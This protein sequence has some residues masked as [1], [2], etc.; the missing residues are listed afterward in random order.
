MKIGAI[1][2]ARTSSTRLPEKVLKEL[3]YRS[4]ITVFEQVIRRLKDSKKL[5]EIIIATTTEEADN[6]IVEI[7]QKE[8]VKYFRGSRDNVLERYYLAAQENHLDVVIRVTSDCPCIDPDIVDMLVDEHLKSSAEYTS[9]SLIRTFPHG[10]DVEVFN[11]KA[12]ET[13]H[14]RAS[15]KFEREH[16][17]PYI[18]KTHS[19][20]F[21]ILKVKAPDELNAPDIR[22]TLDTEEDYSLLCAVFDYLFE[23]NE[24][25]KTRDLIDLFNS[26]PWLKIINKK[27]IQQRGFDDPDDEIKTALELMELQELSTAKKFLEEAYFK[28]P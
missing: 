13:A 20:I 4:G 23:K 15:E 22:I 17:T 27:I 1:I 25:F 7:A 19:E 5:D 6:P 18:Y 16:V 10:L 21:K 9:N 8:G 28:S 14:K 3:P 2:Q 11:F 26:K 24:S 12:L